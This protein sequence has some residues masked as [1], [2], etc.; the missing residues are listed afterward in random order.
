MEYVG[1]H[2]KPATQEEFYADQDLWDTEFDD[3][4]AQPNV[5]P[6]HLTAD[7]T[8][9]GGSDQWGNFLSNFEV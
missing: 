8:Y 7:Q 1:R 6:G 3:P 9:R 4:F 5:N 2:Q